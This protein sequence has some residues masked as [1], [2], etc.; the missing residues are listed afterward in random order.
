MQSVR[1]GLIHDAT[2]LFRFVDSIE[3]FVAEHES[4][5]TYNDAT[6]EYFSEVRSEVKRT[7]NLV[8][9][10][11]DKAS[12][13]KSDDDG[14]RYQRELTIHKNLWK[15]RHTYIKPADDADSLIFQDR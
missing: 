12:Q 1:D 11:L 2:F 14:L 8:L 15:I 6:S 13:P 4:Q 7:K 3:R 9:D 5:F 10:V